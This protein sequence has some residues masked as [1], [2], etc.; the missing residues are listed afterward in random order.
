[1][2]GYGKCTGQR[3][4]DTAALCAPWERNNGCPAP[5][6]RQEAARLSLELCALTY[7]MDVAPWKAA[8]WRDVTCRAVQPEEEGDRGAE[9]NAPGKSRHLMGIGPLLR[10]S[11]SYLQDTLHRKSRK[12]PEKQT[13]MLHPL[14]EGR[15]IVAIGFM[16]TGKQLSD[17]TVNFK[18]DREEE[19]HQGF[20][21][22]TRE[23]EAL[24]EEI[25]FPETAREM[26]R[27]RLTL[28]D[29]ITECCHPHS[30]FTL[31]LAGHSQ[32]GAVMQLY[33]WHLV[34]RGVLRPHI[35]GYGFA[36]PSVFYDRPDH[37]LQDYPLFHLQ[38]G[39]DAVARM[40]AR[41]HVGQCRVMNPDEEM[42]KT[43][44]GALWQDPLFR[45]I[46]SLVTR[47]RDSG[48]VLIFLSALLDALESLPDDEILAVISGVFS[49]VLPDKLTGLLGG[50]IDGLLE[51]LKFRLNRLYFSVIGSASMPRE[52]LLIYEASVSRLIRQYGART[53]ARMLLTVLGT[54]HKL[55][56]KPDYPGQ[57]PYEYLVTQRFGDLKQRIFG[58]AAPLCY[59]KRPRRTAPRLPSRRFAAY[60]RARAEK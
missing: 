29:V 18:I 7:D 59:A 44:Y 47:L 56:T 12:A 55:R 11:L 20:L 48:D 27:D 21:E 37:N 23:F 1:M 35:I 19:A 9:E 42:R 10:E 36:S 58:G 33:A 16:G 51:N 24:E 46:L 30:R 17:W 15:Y 52:K 32:G 25:R 43:C 38:N 31:W 3:L 54:P 14:P 4:D 8:G 50:R 28:K 49:K 6:F 40:G 45:K 53:F 5:V 41:K 57:A 60:S 39:D 34:Q 13:V 26:G 22:V 2:T